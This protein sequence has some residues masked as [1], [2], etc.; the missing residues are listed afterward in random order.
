MQ[1]R[2]E[3]IERRQVQLGKVA[4]AILTLGILAL[5]PVLMMM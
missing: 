4:G 5:M 3:M 2:L 1:K